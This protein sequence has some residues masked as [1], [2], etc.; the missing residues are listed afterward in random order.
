MPIPIVSVLLPAYNAELHLAEAIDSVLH[1]TYPHFELIVINDGSTDQTEAIVLSYSDPR[2]RYER[3][4]ANLGLISTLNKG[5]QMAKGAYIARMDADDI[6]YPDRLKEQVDFMEQHP[7]VGIAGSWFE[8]LNAGKKTKGAPPT[9]DYH[10]RSSLIMATTLHHPTVIIRSSLLEVEGLNFSYDAQ[11]QHVEDYHL[12]VKAAPYTTFANVPKVLLQYRQHPQS[13]CAQYSGVQRRR[14]DQVRMLTFPLFLGIPYEKRL[15]DLIHSRGTFIPD[16][17]Y[18]YLL[19]QLKAI[20]TAILE[21]G[22]DGR[23]FNRRFAV[24]LYPFFH[25]HHHLGWR[26]FA[27]FLRSGIYRWLPLKEYGANYVKFFLKTLL[28]FQP[29]KPLA[30]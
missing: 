11:F 26:N 14:F 9:D 20:N 28:A 4:T 21:R 27:C 2:I 18:Q 23:F 6:C 10:I 7:K 16:R 30:R 12:W 13:I 29:V 25:N 8:Y 24:M 17:E 19:S 3:N 1:Q 22:W 5:L 15:V